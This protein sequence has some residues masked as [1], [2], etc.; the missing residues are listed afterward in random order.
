MIVLLASHLHFD[1]CSLEKGKKVHT[2]RLSSTE[3]IE[4]LLIFVD[5]RAN[6]ERTLLFALFP[7]IVFLTVTLFR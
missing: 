3:I 5:L 1:L 6:G 2:F 7:D 4:L